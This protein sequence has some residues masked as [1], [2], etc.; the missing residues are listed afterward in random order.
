[1]WLT[2]FCAL[3][4]MISSVWITLWSI[5]VFKMFLEIR[6]QVHSVVFA[7]SWQINKQKYAKTINLLCAGNK[8]F[9]KYQAQGG[10]NPNPPLRTSLR[11]HTRKCQRRSTLQCTSCNWQNTS[12]VGRSSKTILNKLSVDRDQGSPTWCPRAPGRPRGSC[13]SPA[14]LLW[15]SSHRL[16]SLIIT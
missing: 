3:V 14:G 15:A 5:S 9:V 1:V 6:M 2:I 12:C 8:V 7:I 13:W 4:S 10:G 11:R 16:T